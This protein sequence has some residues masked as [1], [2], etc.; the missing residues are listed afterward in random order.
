LKVSLSFEVHQPYRINRN[1]KEEYARNR[2]NLVDIYFNNSWNKEVFKKVAG[3]CYY[4]AT[5]IILENLD[6]FDDFSVSYSFSGVMLE[7][8][9]KWEP[10]LLALFKE[11]ANRKNVEILAQ[12]YY[13]SLAGLFETNDEFVEQIKLHVNLMTDLFGKK[14]KPRVFENTEFLFNNNIAAIAGDLGFKA[15]FTEGADR[16]LGWRSPNYTYTSRDGKLKVLLKNYRLSD[17]IAFRFSNRDWEGFPLTADKFA[18]WVAYTP[19]DCINLFMDY[20]TLG[21]HQW[22]ETGILDFVKWLPG[23]ILKRNIEFSL[24]SEIAMLEPVGE[25]DVNVYETVSWA[26]TDRDTSAW[27]GNDMQRTCFRSIQKMEAIVKSSGDSLVNIW[28]LL[29]ISDLL[30][31]MYTKEGPSG[32]VHGYFSQQYPFEVFSAYLRI[33]SDLFVKCSEKLK[34]EKKTA[35]KVLRTVPPEK[36]FH[37]YN[38]KN[39]INL[40]AHSLDELLETLKIVDEGSF[41]FHFRGGD[42]ER[43]IRYTVGDSTLAKRVKKAEN[44]QQFIEEVERR[45]EELWKLFE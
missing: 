3:K 42:F 12:T 4:P 20:E 18:T 21:E 37:Y 16:I 5:E 43:W 25:I 7:Q 13:H 32:I 29:Q 44:K 31:Y 24:P 6:E 10:D 39:Y 26:D 1:F 35:A 27:L 41:G 19:G 8:C 34:G 30:Y 15:I 23:E 38:D 40:S 28:R 36:A 17:D 45:C 11:L 22:K 2:K 33:L 14:K 9:E